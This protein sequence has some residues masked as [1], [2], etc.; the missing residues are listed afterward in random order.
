MRY[1]KLAIIPIE[2]G[3]AKG[4]GGG[5]GGGYYDVIV[6]NDDNSNN[7]GRYCTLLAKLQTWA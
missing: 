7:Y 5:L 1:G 4:E 3:T 2:A 6:D